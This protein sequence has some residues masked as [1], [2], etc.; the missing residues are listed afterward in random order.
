M[1][2]TEFVTA[3][4]LLRPLNACDDENTPPHVGTVNPQD[5]S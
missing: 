4:H 5:Q 2:V 1:Q 3:C